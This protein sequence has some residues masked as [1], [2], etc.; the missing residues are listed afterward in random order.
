MEEKTES[1]VENK[2][3][4]QVNTDFNLWNGIKIA[5]VLIGGI[6]LVQYLSKKKK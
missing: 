2:E 5:I 6:Y 4:Q 1:V 3:L